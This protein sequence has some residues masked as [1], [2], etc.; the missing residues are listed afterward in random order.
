MFTVAWRPRTVTPPASPATTNSVIAVCAVHG[1][2]IRRSIAAPVRASQVDVD[3][4][5][6]RSR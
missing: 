2:G 1:D 4:R 3:L 5:S 6:R